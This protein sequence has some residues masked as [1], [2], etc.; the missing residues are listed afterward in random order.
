MESAAPASLSPRLRELGASDRDLVR[1][2]RTFN[3][4]ANPFRL[5]SEAHEPH[6]EG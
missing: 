6:A 3:A 4:G 2:Y 5:E 1:I